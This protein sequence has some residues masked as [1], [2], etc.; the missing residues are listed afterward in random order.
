MGIALYGWQAHQN[1]YASSWHR[2]PPD[3]SCNMN[4][5]LSGKEK[6]SLLN[7]SEKKFTKKFKQKNI[8]YIVSEQHNS[9]AISN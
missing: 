9:K 5:C 6:Y 1:E 3:F 4:V 7:K 2:L 8:C